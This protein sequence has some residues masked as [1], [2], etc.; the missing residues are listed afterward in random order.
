MTHEI[1]RS[2]E[3]IDELSNQCA[4]QENT[5]GSKYPGMTYEQG[6]SAAIDWLTQKEWDHPLDD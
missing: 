6:I 2:D 4:D 1:V 5:G 3:E